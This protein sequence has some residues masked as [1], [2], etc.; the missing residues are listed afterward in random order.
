GLGSATR[1]PPGAQRAR[2]AAITFTYTRL[3][4]PRRAFPRIRRGSARAPAAQLSRFLL[5]VPL[6]APQPADP[7]VDELV[8]LSVEDSAGVPGLHPGADVFDALV[9]VEHVV[10]HLGSPRPRGLTAER[11]ELGLLLL[12]FAFQQLGLEDRHRGSAVLQLGAFVLAGDQD[13]G[14]QVGDP[15]R[16]VGGVD[17]LAA[18]P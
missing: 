18:G 2:Q 16:R 8:D 3:S 9:G 10:A 6:P 17:A 14:R 7:S 1:P 4:E 5:L 12:A 15:H 13:P 11:G